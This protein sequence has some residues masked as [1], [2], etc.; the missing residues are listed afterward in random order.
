MYR[1]VGIGG[2]SSVHL[3]TLPSASEAGYELVGNGEDQSNY[4]SDNH[5]RE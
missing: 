1:L 4:T 3:L 5:Q 2:N